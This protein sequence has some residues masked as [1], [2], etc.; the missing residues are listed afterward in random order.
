MDYE[1]RT[2]VH[3]RMAKLL[4]VVILFVLAYIPLTLSANNDEPASFTTSSK[5]L[6]ALSKTLPKRL[7]MKGV[8][9]GKQ[10]PVD[11]ILERYE[12]FSPNASFLL[13]D[14]GGGIDRE[15]LKS[16]TYYRGSVVGFKGSFAFLTVDE[17]VGDVRGSVELTDR[18]WSLS[19]DSREQQLIASKASR[20]EMKLPVDMVKD[21]EIPLATDIS[22]SKYEQEQ[23]LRDRQL[24]R[25]PT[26]KLT[27]SGSTLGTSLSLTEYNC[28]T[29]LYEQYD[30]LG[31]TREGGTACVTQFNIPEG[32]SARFTLYGQDGN[33]G[34][35]D[36]YVR[37]GNPSAIECE[38]AGETVDEV[39]SDIASGIVEVVVAA[40]ETEVSYW[41]RFEKK[42]LAT[43]T[44]E[45]QCY[46][47]A[48]NDYW[49]HDIDAGSSC[50]YDFDIPDGVT[51]TFTLWGRSD[52]TG[53][54]DMLVR[55]GDPA[56][57]VCTS[58]GSSVNEHC[59]GIESGSV[60]VVVSAPTDSVKIALDYALAIPPLAQGTQYE[61]V[62]AVDL[63]YLTYEDLGSLQDVQNYIAELFAYTNVVYER[64][65]ETK[66]VVGD[67]RVRQTTDDDPYHTDE[68]LST[69]CRL[70]ELNNKW[71][72]SEELAAVE[73]ST[74][75][76]LTATSFGGLATL[77]GLCLEPYSYSSPQEIENCPFDRDSAGGFSV[78]GAQ[79]EVSAIGTG[80]AFA[81]MV[82]AHELGHNFNSQHSHGYMG[83]GGNEN[84]VDACYVEEDQGSHYW[85]GETSLPGTGSLQGGANGERNGTIMSYCHQLPGGTT[86]NQSMTFGKD[87]AY[88]V[89]PDRIPERMRNFVGAIALTNTS[90]IGTVNTNS[91]SDGDGFPDAEDAFPDDPN[92]WLDTDGDG[93][94]NNTD[95]DDDNDGFDDEYDAFPKDASE[96]Y[97]SDGDGVGD[98]G[99]ETYDP[100][101]VAIF[102]LL[103]RMDRCSSPS[104]LKFEVDG[105]LSPIVRAGERLQTRLAHGSH[106]IRILDVAG[107]ELAKEQL[108]VSGSSS[109]GW[110]C[111]W[112]GWT[113]D[114]FVILE[115]SDG[116]LVIDELDDYPN[117]RSQSPTILTVTPSAGLGGSIS[118]SSLQTIQ[119]GATTSFT[120]TPSSGYRID[121]MGGTCDGTL[122]GSTY[123]TAAVTQDC[124]VTATFVEFSGATYIV[125]PAAGA[126]GSISPSIP[127]TVEEGASTSFTVMPSS[128]YQIDAVGGTCNGNL[129]GSTYTTAAVTQD[130]TVLADFIE[131]IG[132]MPVW[133]MYLLIMQDEVGDVEGQSNENR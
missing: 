45:K 55:R 119:E 52:N 125:T 115:D 16:M 113:L 65:V 23:R 24:V 49:F 44:Y 89:Q 132:G 133:L 26:M 121:A 13:G 15:P 39:C 72:G 50:I 66:L 21:Y 127:Q 12:A 29:D 120:V 111:S 67:M 32:Y 83:F 28:N 63:D 43:G 37:R 73:R 62:V 20:P 3:R 86:G 25:Q 129:S 53:D 98:N 35:G 1:S 5:S 117:D 97:D 14:P 70:A 64:E 114:D 116:D 59:G 102:N 34:N 19:L 118:P 41:L 51:G 9:L 47:P 100:S 107:E 11:L 103:N 38:S 22:Q 108:M 7:V 91:D 101:E 87:F 18:I 95:T 4:T 109:W 58:D 81:D 31:W 33:E 126:G 57:T 80:P 79:G 110:G 130:C 60:E 88:G 128:G 77:G 30:T 131:D 92:E 106:L 112:D 90:C 61:A 36:L 71:M 76:H 6:M 78:S 54:A 40:P 17:T 94:G 10:D 42:N 75:A 74:V 82:P 46:A 48:V 99:D 2:S 122:S 104:A 84:P 96:W 68:E 93:L 123:T 85:A 124:T 27:G 56:T 8:V 105:S 69:A